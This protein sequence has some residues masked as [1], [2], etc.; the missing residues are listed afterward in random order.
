LV[1]GSIVSVRLETM[2]AGNISG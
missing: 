2:T 1:L